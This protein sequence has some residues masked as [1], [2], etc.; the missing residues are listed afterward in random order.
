MSNEN[1]ISITG[2]LGKDVE[3]RYT[4]G[5]R[6]VSSFSVATNRRWMK[7]NE[8]QEE[9]CWH[10]VT[11]WGEL[12]EN[13]AAS[14]QKG[15]R[16]MVTGRLST[17]SY[18]DREGNKKYITEIIADNIGAELRFAQV[19]VARTERTGPSD[20]EQS[21]AGGRPAQSSGRR[22]AAGWFDDEEPF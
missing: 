22:T 6:G 13:V 14:L 19:T 3:L 2:T 4:T 1:V 16:V 15:N 10:N 18:D 8:W 5:G 17:R 21:N 20:R 12:G 9:T 7:D 11:A